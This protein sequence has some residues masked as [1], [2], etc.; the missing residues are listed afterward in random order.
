MLLIGMGAAPLAQAAEQPQ[1]GGTLQVALAGDPPSL[2]KHQ[3]STFMVTIPM[4]PAYNTLITLDPH[5]YPRIVGDLA[6]SWTISDDHLSYTFKLHEG[7]KFYRQG[8]L[9][10]DRL[11]ARG[12][13]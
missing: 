2:D 5:H 9:R 6:T 12:G 8:Q 4:S 3:E 10:Q 7:M 11:A 13:D 1:Y